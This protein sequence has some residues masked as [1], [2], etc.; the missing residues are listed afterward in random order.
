MNSQCLARAR[1]SRQLE[2]TLDTTIPDEVYNKL[3][4]ELAAR[5]EQ[6]QQ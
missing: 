4:Q 2:R 1:K 3:E 5:E 6:Q